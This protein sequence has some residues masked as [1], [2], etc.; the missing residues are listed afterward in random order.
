MIAVEESNGFINFILL[1]RELALNFR[2]KAEQV[3]NDNDFYKVFFLIFCNL[4]QMKVIA[5]LK[6]C[7]PEKHGTPRQGLKAPTTRGI[8]TLKPEVGVES[9]VGLEDFG[10]IWLVFVF[11][12][13]SGDYSTQKTKIRAP[14][15]MGKKVGI[16]ASRTPH[17]V[18]PIGLTLC[19]LDKIVKN[20]LFISG[21][22]LIDQTPILDIKPYHPSD[23]VHSAYPSW[24]VDATSIPTLAVTWKNEATAELKRIVKRGLLEFYSKQEYDLV[25]Q[26]IED[27][28]KLDPRSVHSK[29]HH[30]H[31]VYAFAIDRLHV[32]FHM[33]SPESAEILHIE[34]FNSLGPTE[35]LRTSAW[36]R[37][38]AAQFDLE[39]DTKYAKE[40]TESDDEDKL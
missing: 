38:I 1:D 13:H 29:K 22:D 2:P 40:S 19:K 9:L 27:C 12:A 17:R 11:H 14:R 39:I 10:H 21:I 3:L 16:F 8:V 35:Q 31:G 24:V 4:R 5:T 23:E 32:V 6:S 7:F 26:A 25:L 18:N 36:L 34:C 15:L 33:L 28:L 20:Q 37:R 30:S